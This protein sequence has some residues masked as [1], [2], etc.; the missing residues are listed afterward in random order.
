MQATELL[1]LL[2]KIYEKSDASF[3]GVYAADKLPLPEYISAHT[4]CAYIA[5]TDQTGLPGRHWIAVFH[6]TKSSIEFFDSFG[7][8][9]HDLGYNFSSFSLKNYNKTQIQCKN[10]T[11]CGQYCVY[12]LYFRIHGHSFT[13]IMAR[14]YTL[15]HS[16]SDSLVYTFINA[17]KSVYKIK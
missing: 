14:L 16:R 12:F 13:N 4:P 2:S 10:S 9:P 8:H 5:N 15:P 7:L 11:V 17:L 1:L 3:L 6:P